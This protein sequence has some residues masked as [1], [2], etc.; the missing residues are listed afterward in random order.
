[1]VVTLSEGEAGQDEGITTS[2]S[3]KDTQITQADTMSSPSLP[4][5]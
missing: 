1:M 5:S 4:L 3:D 2:T